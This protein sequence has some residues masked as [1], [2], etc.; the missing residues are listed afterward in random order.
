[1]AAQVFNPPA[2]ERGEHGRRPRSSD[3]KP[4]N[5]RGVCA[6]ATRRGPRKRGVVEVGDSGLR[7]QQ[8][9][10]GKPV[11]HPGVGGPRE[12]GCHAPHKRG[13]ILIHRHV[14]VPRACA[15]RNGRGAPVC[16]VV[17]AKCY[18]RGRHPVF[19]SRYR[20]NVGKGKGRNGHRKNSVLQGGV[21][22]YA[23]HG[24]PLVRHVAGVRAAKGEVAV[25]C[26][27]GQLQVCVKG[28]A[29]HLAARGVHRSGVNK[30]PGGV[31]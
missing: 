21:P 9:V 29:Q 20:Y 3:R 22:V 7:S 27:A 6:D 15:D 13:A 19:V 30:R 1:M 23:H 25:V 16:E 5:A 11:S 10:S 28:V 26:A 4:F 24:A 14:R 31:Q 8:R 2:H 17:S 12:L 18:T